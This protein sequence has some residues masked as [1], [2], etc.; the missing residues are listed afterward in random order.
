MADSASY[1]VEQL[2]KARYGL[3]HTINKMIEADALDFPPEKKDEIKA[4]LD[5]LVL[6]VEGFWDFLDPDGVKRAALTKALADN[7]GGMQCTAINV[8]EARCRKKGHWTQDER[9][10]RCTTHAAESEPG[11]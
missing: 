10:F 7:G 6:Y 1:I 8:T 3:N 4:A 2:R 5:D 9:L 11:E